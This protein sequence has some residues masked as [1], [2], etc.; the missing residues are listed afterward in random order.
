[1]M[2]PTA[3][4]MHRPLYLTTSA[5]LIALT[6]GACQSTQ[7]SDP[8]AANA[9]AKSVAE[10][11]IT[12]TDKGCEPNAINVKAGETT[13][14]ITNKSSQPLEWEILDGIKVLEEREN[15]APGFVQKLK[16]SLDAGQYD[17]AC[18]LRSN[19][20]GKLTVKAGQD[21]IQA[22][23][24]DQ[25]KVV[26][27]IAE[28]KVYILGEVEQLVSKTKPFTDAVIA[29]DV[30]T[31]KKLY[32]PARVHWERS[33]PIAELFSDL[34]GSMD[35]RE[36]DFAKKAD[37]PNFTGFH[38]LEK[39][40]FKDNTTAGM[41]PIAEKL[42]ADTLILQKRI[43]TL[44]IEPKAMVGGAAALIE[45]VAATKI[46]GEED[47]YS[48]TD[49]WDF[50]ANIDGSEKIVNLLR[51]LLEKADPALLSS[52]DGN[53]Q[54]INT[55]LAKYKVPEGGFVSY[56]KLTDGDRKQLKTIIATHAEALSKLR[57]TLG[58]D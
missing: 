11:P 58:V 33:E 37:D 52:I 2:K 19:P 50:Q 9:T 40:L 36:D 30:E 21:G 34:D 48:R 42:M 45:E 25:G 55:R 13:F 3:K 10:V 49:L 14:I 8:T 38:R 28:Y 31:A 24:V 15:I 32:A 7:S 27:A 41:K 29:G 51:P 26:G 39:A 47:R 20:K 17:M 4:S 44:A 5:C 16:A 53:F 54:Q 12:I 18:G 35:A 43:K 1:M 23:T 22:Q 56:D 46:S 57:G 6:V